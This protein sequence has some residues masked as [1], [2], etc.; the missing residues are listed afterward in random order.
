MVLDAP[1]IVLVTVSVAVM[2]CVPAAS[3]VAEK[4]PVPLGSAEGNGRVAAPS[5]LVKSTVPEYP[6]LVFPSASSAV[7]VNVNED[8]AVAVAGAE[9]LKRAAGPGPTVIE[10]DVPV[11]DEVTVSVAVIVCDPAVFR[12]VL[13]EPVP[14]VRGESAGRTAA[15]S[16]DVK[17]TVPP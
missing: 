3:S 11:I 15:P 10:P 12:V 13:N 14:D 6:G 4:V 9:T 8:P 16:V 17:C 2:V 7:T 1:V 5:L